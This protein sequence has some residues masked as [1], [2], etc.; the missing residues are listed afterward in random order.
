VAPARVVG[1][2]VVGLLVLAGLFILSIAIGANNMPLDSVWRGLT[3]DSTERDTL[4]EAIIVWQLRMP[5]TLLAIAAGAALAVAGVVMQALTRNPLAEPGLLGVNSGAAFAVVCATLFLGITDASRYVWFAF[6]GAAAV[7]CLVYVVSVRRM[8]RSDRVHLVLVGAAISAALSSCT[9][10][11]TMS[12]TD[13]FN[14]YRFWVIGSTADR[15]YDVLMPLLPLFLTGFVLAFAAGPALNAM[16]LGDEQAQ[17]L[18]VRLAAARSVSLLAITL[19]CGATTAACGPISFV[20]LA[21]PHML[22]L[23]VGVDQR[24]LLVFSLLTGPSFLLGADIIGRVAAAGELEVG[25]VTAFLG[26]PVLIAIL[27]RKVR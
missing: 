20:G 26:A 23:L 24:R 11:L 18:G 4:P 3:A 27:L 2:V 12:H 10:V 7:A 16:A 14:S 13:V 25:I 15:G 21:I 22:R 6:A 17:A 9:G 8:T 19:L 1:A 5:R